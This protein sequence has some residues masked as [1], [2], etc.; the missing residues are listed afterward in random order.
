MP[1]EVDRLEI[2]KIHMKK[3]KIKEQSFDNI[4][5]IIVKSTENFNG[6]D[7][8]NLTNQVIFIFIYIYFN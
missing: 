1:N 8:S 7:I 3:I 4:A 6:A 5:N 2:L